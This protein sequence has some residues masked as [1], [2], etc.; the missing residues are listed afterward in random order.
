M[1]FTNDPKA[2]E[3]CGFDVATPTPF[4]GE[5]KAGTNAMISVPNAKTNLGPLCTAPSKQGN[6]FVCDIN[7]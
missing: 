5:H 1:R 4:N 2:A 6:T 7:Q 3:P